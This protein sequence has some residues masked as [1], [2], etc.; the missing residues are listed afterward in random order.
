MI[1][2]GSGSA[3]RSPSAGD[4]SQLVEKRKSSSPRL[5]SDAAG[6]LPAVRRGTFSFRLDV[7]LSALMGPWVPGVICQTRGHVLAKRVRFEAAWMWHYVRPCGGNIRTETP[8]PP[9]TQEQ[10]QQAP[11]RTDQVTVQ[12]LLLVRVF[13]QSSGNEPKC[14]DGSGSDPEQLWGRTADGLRVSPA[15]SSPLG[16]RR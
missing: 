7:L 5:A 9:K 8:P 13:H 2:S 4:E 14:F 16:V 1:N 15:P 3:A 11:E 12:Y 6:S 10:G